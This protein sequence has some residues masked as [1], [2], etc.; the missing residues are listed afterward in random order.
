[1]YITSDDICIVFCLNCNVLIELCVV[2]CSVLFELFVFYHIYSLLQYF[3]FFWLFCH[4]HLGHRCDGSPN[5]RL[6]SKCRNISNL[7]ERQSTISS[8]YIQK[9][10]IYIYIYLV[11]KNVLFWF[12]FKLVIN[13]PMDVMFSIDAVIYF[14]MWFQ[15]AKSAGRRDDKTIP[16][17]A[18]GTKQSEHYY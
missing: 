4:L 1:L 13:L 5:Q 6:R 15:Y 3:A 17:L 2:L 14:V 11:F 7:L 9:K 8:K 18:K 10:Y 16:L 12:F